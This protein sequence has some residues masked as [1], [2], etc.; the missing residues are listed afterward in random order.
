LPTQRQVGQD[1]AKSLNAVVVDEYIDKDTGTRTDK[2]PAMQALLELVRTKRDVDYVIVFKLDRW[3]RN[4]REDL[5]N[6]YL[7][8]Q[9]GAELV[10]CSEQIDRSNAGRMSH[11]MLAGMNEYQSRNAGDEIR[12]KTLVKVQ[13]GGTPGVAPLGYKNVGEGG[14]RYVVIDPEP[15]RLIT[16]AFEAYATG[17]WS[18]ESLLT[19]ITARGLRSR[20]GPNTPSKEL[21]LAQL[22]RILRRPYY[23]GIVTF[24]DVT[25]QGKHEPIVDE[26]TWQRVQDIM[27][28]NRNGE[29]QREHP[30]YLKGTIFC[31]HCGSRLCV[32][33]SRSKTGRLYPYYFCVGRH[34]KR[35]TCMLKHRRIE[36]VESQ[37]ED[38]YRVVA[39][40]AEGLAETAEAISAE[41][42][43]EQTFVVDE[44]RRQ[45]ERLRQ[46]DDERVKL[47]HAHYAGAV[48]ID[49]LKREQDRITSD[50]AATTAALAATAFTAEQIETTIERAVAWA[51]SCHQAYLAASPVQRRL[52]NQAF[53]TRVLVTED[54]ITGWEYNQPFAL[55]MAAHAAAPR[56]DVTNQPS[57]LKTSRSKTGRA[58]RCQSRPRNG[59]SPSWLAWAVHGSGS[60]DEHVAVLVE[61]RLN[62]VAWWELAGLVYSVRTGDADR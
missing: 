41:L 10:S 53:F 54:G 9:A 25:Y 40:N 13:E 19:E 44:R 17:E 6:D 37:I 62:P 51:Q 34:Q 28:G 15:A 23:K 18:V 42:E 47:L 58:E 3:A 4:A 26:D 61:Q 48:P 27:S 35:T 7:L 32:S 59:N 49:L 29:K 52:M 50:I 31:G 24:N 12:R 46:L 45:Q 1:K 22:H 43:A 60:K 36:L 33:Y 30:H 39:L 16:W 8:E 5:V 56:P 55:L 11:V 38:H 20:G 2:R 14:R 57:V 21:S